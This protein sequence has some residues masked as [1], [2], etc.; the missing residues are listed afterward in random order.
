MCR[1]IVAFPLHMHS[2]I[3]TE[4]VEQMIVMLFFDV[5]MIPHAIGEGSI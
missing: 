1:Q 5:I 2:C 3:P 4:K